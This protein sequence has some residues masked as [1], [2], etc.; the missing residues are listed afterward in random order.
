MW[1]PL[2]SALLCATVFIALTLAAPCSAQL[3]RVDT[4]EKSLEIVEQTGQDHVIFLYDSLDLNSLKALEALGEAELARDGHTVYTIDVRTGP[5][6]WMLSQLDSF[7]YP[8]MRV[9]RR[10]EGS[11]RQVVPQD[12]F[13]YSPKEIAAL[14]RSIRK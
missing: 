12:G 8:C 3:V 9:L 4:V 5:S 1:L 13:G 10:A 7:S 11:H 14:M 2:R 6:S